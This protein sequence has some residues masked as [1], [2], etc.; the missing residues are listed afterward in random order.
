MEKKTDKPN[1]PVVICIDTELST[2]RYYFKI[3]VNGQ[4]EDTHMGLEWNEAVKLCRANKWAVVIG[5]L[6]R[7]LCRA[8]KVKKCCSDGK[9][10]TYQF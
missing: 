5:D 9:L 2:E 10:I 1:V 7:K 4:P 6:P 3:L 8:L